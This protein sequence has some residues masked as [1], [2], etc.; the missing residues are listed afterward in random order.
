MTIFL[1]PRRARWYAVAAPANPPPT[2]TASA[3][4]MKAPYGLEDDHLPVARGGE[5]GGSARGIRQ[6]DGSE[7]AH[8]LA[9]DATA[10]HR[11]DVAIVEQVECLRR[12]RPVRVQPQTD[13][14]VHQ[15]IAG[16]ERLADV[17]D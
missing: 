9:R 1:R 12:Q 2:T 14:R 10:V 15:R 17:V 3:V 6:V 11:L 5:R 7:A 16:L 8:R 13:P 4:R